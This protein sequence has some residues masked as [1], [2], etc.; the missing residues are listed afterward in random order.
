LEDAIAG[1][2]AA[3]GGDFDEAIRLYTK[4]IESGELSREDLSNA[5][6]NR[7][8]SWYNKGDYDKAI[9]DYSKA[10][11]INPEW[12]RCYYYRGNVWGTKGDYDRAIADFTKAIEIDPEYA[13]A[14]NNRGDAWQEKGDYDRAITDYTKTIGIA[15][16]YVNALNGLA[17]L[18]ATCR[19]ERYR[20]GNRAVEFAEK[21][22]ELED[23][24]GILDTLAAAYAEA[25]R[26]Q[27]AIETQEIAITKLKQEDGTTKD[28]DEFEQHLS[29]YKARKPWRE[30]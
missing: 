12:S 14:Y 6:F 17:W 18:M 28:Q 2:A 10:I 20:D 29:S 27:D 13:L 22:V 30:R 23:D 26:F 7:G 21:A 24:A 3:S 19:E 25:G 11:E 1:M 9:A 16:E 4:A 8:V 5:Y 15:P